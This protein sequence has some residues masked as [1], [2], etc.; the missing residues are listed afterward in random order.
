MTLKCMN[1]YILVIIF[2]LFISI[3][4]DSWS[5]EIKLTYIDSIIYDE[6]GGRLYFPNYVFVDS[7]MDE[8]YVIDNLNRIIIYTSDFFPAYTFDKKHGIIAPASLSV[9]PEGFV[10]ITMQT[11]KTDKRPRIYVF[12]PTFRLNREIVIEGIPDADSFKPHRLVLDKKGNI[13]VSGG[14]YR[15][16]A[17]LDNNGKFIDIISPEEDGRKVYINNLSVDGSGRIYLISEEEGRIYVYDENRRYLFKFGEKG[18]SSG[19]LSRPQALAVDDVSGRIYVTDYMRHAVNVYD[20]NGLYI[21]EFG[22]FGWSPGWF[23]YPIGIFFDHKGRLM[24]VDTFNN[25]V[26]VFQAR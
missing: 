25:R 19:K 4:F 3:P 15:G 1:K 14:Y 18:G 13:Y 21:S 6:E 8:I 23:A 11:T 16:I 2:L 17:I 24:V 26:Q 12:D 10:Y 9:D 7:V 5:E 22:G 20:R